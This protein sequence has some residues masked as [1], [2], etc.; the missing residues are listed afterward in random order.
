[1]QLLDHL[2]R[3]RSIAVVG[4]GATPTSMGSRL[5][6]N[7]L[8]YGFAGRVYAINRDG[9][10]SGG[11]DGFRKITEIDGPVDVAFVAVAAKLAPQIVADCAAHGVAV[12]Q[13]FSSTYGEPGNPNQAL[14]DAAR[15]ITRIVGPNCLGTH[16]PH[17]RITYVPGPDRNAGSV[18]IVS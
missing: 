9:E 14:I 3:P 18:A 16:S 2:F 13:I 6:K 4:A 7:I 17:G 12:A 10:S 5:V 8:D 15:N 1:M 11:V